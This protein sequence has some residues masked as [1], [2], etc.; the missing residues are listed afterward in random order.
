MITTTLLAFVLATP[1]SPNPNWE[2]AKIKDVICSNVVIVA[3]DKDPDLWVGLLGVGTPETV[4]PL[5]DKFLIGKPDPDWLRSWLP[6]GTPV[7]MERRGE[8]ASGRPLVFLYRV[9]DQFCYNSFLVR[10]GGAFAAKQIEFP[11]FA[12]FA[13]LE[14]AARE[15]GTGLWYGYQAQLPADHLVVS[16][17]V[18]GPEA[19][20]RDPE[21]GAGAA[22]GHS[23]SPVAPAVPA[24]S[25]VG[26]TVGAQPT[27]RKRR[28]YVRQDWARFDATLG[29]MLNQAP[30]APQMATAPARSV[31]SAS[32]GGSHLCGYPTRDGTPCMRMV[33]DGNGIYCWQHG[34]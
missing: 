19:T 14:R 30:S 21:I 10:S 17:Q 8:T 26:E 28:S 29:N 24:R 22:R 12:E 16:N 23:P 9:G 1:Q 32:S 15:R 5:K 6:R 4:D 33:K 18:A 13:G 3:T 11:E 31:G 34:G 25:S 27:Y 20:V 7:W 2:L